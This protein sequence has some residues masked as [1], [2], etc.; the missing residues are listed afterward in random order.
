MAVLPQPYANERN[1][2]SKVRQSLILLIYQATFI[3]IASY[4]CFFLSCLNTEVYLTIWIHYHYHLAQP[5]CLV[6]ALNFYCTILPIITLPNIWLKI[7]SQRLHSSPLNDMGLQVWNTRAHLYRFFF[8]IYMSHNLQ[9]TE[10]LDVELQ[11]QKTDYKVIHNFWLCRCMRLC[12]D[13]SHQH[14]SPPHCSRINCTL[15]S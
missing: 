13:W 5:T 1:L 4:C 7:Y 8:S 14:P 10:S 6:S 3:G 11:I 15:Y 9:L 12:G 2:L